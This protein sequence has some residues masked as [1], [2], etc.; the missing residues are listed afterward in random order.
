[1]DR[2]AHVS[3]RRAVQKP[4]CVLPGSQEQVAASKVNG[5]KSEGRLCTAFEVG[6]VEEA[7]AA[8]VVLDEDWGIISG[9][10][11][12]MAPPTVRT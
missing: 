12:P 6:W 9:D 5:V 2:T 11:C 1:M 3:G 4:G 7:T 8:L 10:V